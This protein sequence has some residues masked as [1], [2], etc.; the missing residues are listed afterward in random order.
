M[1]LVCLLLWVR[2]QD[3]AA[4]ARAAAEK[5]AADEAA[6]KSAAVCD[7]ALVCVVFESWH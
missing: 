2:S 7:R 6:A 1:M 4:A 3:A 5:K